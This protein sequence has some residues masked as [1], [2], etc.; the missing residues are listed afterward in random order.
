MHLK[1]RSLSAKPKRG[2]CTF[3]LTN[4]EEKKLKKEVFHKNLKYCTEKIIFKKLEVVCFQWK[5]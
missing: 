4:F 1:K 3:E 2:L 5:I